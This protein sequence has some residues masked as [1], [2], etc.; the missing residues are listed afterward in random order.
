MFV[1]V[2]GIIGLSSCGHKTATSGTLIIKLNPMLGS[3]T[4]AL[5]HVYPCLD[6]NNY[7]FQDFQ[8]FLSHIKLIYTNGDSVEVEP[9]AYFSLDDG[10]CMSIS[11]TAPAGSYKGIRFNIGLD[12]TQDAMPVDINDTINPLSYAHSNIT[13][14]DPTKEYVFTFIDGYA[15]HSANPSTSFEYHVGTAPY[16][17]TAPVLPKNFSVSGGSQTLVLNA[18][19]QNIFYGS[20][21][22]INITTQNYTET[23]SSNDPV[24][25]K[26]ID[27]FSQIFSLQ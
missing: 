4:I 24:A 10:A 5:Q 21:S 17:V 6:G 8:F 1:L 14:G 13:W 12:P 25:F 11:V 7:N 23:A 2:I 9:M 3:N 20:S 27:D 22:A 15:D 18:Q 19:M 26:F 16:Y